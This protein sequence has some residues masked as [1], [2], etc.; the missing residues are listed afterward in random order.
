MFFSVFFFHNQ[1]YVSFYSLIFL[2][3]SYFALLVALFIS[4]TSM[5]KERTT[6]TENIKEL[7][8]AGFIILSTYFHI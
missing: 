5:T 8:I 3:V 7:K 1:I 4:I 6:T 2:I